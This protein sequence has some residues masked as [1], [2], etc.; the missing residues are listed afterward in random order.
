MNRKA[1]EIASEQIDSPSHVIAIGASAGGLEAIQAFFDN[2]PPDLGVAFIVIQHLSPDFKSMMDELLVKNTSMPAHQAVE[3]EVLKANTIYLIPAGKLM[4]VVERTIY[5]SDLPP[6]NRINLPINEFFK[7]LAESEQHNA[8][9]IVL[10]GTGSDGSRGVQALKEVGG[11]VMCQDPK[12]TQFDGMPVNAINTGCVDFVLSVED[13]PSHIQDFISSPHRSKNKEQTELRIFDDFETV[14][15]I[16]EVIKRKT[17]VDFRAYKE[18]TISRRIEHRMAILGHTNLGEYF[19]YLKSRHDEANQ[20]KQDL[21]I[22]VTQFFRDTEV[23]ARVVQEV[24]EPLLQSKKE[25]ETIRVWVPGCSTGEEAY[26]IGMLFLNTM[27]RLNKHHILKI[28]ASDIDQSAI[29]FGAN[30]VYPASITTEVSQSDI[31]KYFVM[32]SD[33][34]FQVA[35]HLRSVVVFAT[36]N[37]IQDP[38]F[39]NMDL[40]SCRN[41]LIYLQ[42]EA[43]QKALAFFH[44]ALKLNGSLVLGSAETTNSLTSYFE[45]IDTRMRV[46]RKNRDVRIPVTAISNNANITSKGYHPRSIPQ[47]IE[48]NKVISKN[49]TKSKDIGL[50]VLVDAYLPASFI[51]NQKGIVVYTYGDTEPYTRKLP[52]G[53]VTNDISDILRGDIVGPAVTLVHQVLRENKRICFEQLDFAGDKVFA[54]NLEGIPFEEETNDKRYIALTIRPISEVE[55]TNITK[56]SY[57]EQAQRRIEELDIALIESQKLYREALEDLDTTSEELQSSNEELMAANEE[58]QSTNEELQSVNEELYTVNGEYQQKISELTVINDDLEN[59]FKATSLAVLFLDKNLL[60]RRF[61]PTMK[62]FLNVIEL[63]INRPIKD[64]TANFDLKDVYE[65][66]HYVNKTGEDRMLEKDVD[67][68][69]I[70]VNVTPY[71]KSM[72]NEGVVMTIRKQ[73]SHKD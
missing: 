12:E 23:W 29:A 11:L 65:I 58:L 71:R 43:Q 19:K 67:G 63:D 42:N 18:S 53:E 36:H 57:D 4:R 1:N 69:I 35:K 55:T 37:L 15:A 66:L 6:D 27:E 47:F 72:A 59:L 61:T 50:K 60:I 44:F 22:G 46:Y 64:I 49:T 8:I 30:G 40:V 25:G 38:P 10:S 17:E 62:E 31:Q 56:Y 33:G 14:H 45:I 16:L 73:L 51:V 52:S 20:L 48:R 7:S 24:I 2:T 54:Y 32:L 39:S 13:M 9:G 34:S 28:F 41:T 3:G 68:E 26:T 5:L 21:L 70:L